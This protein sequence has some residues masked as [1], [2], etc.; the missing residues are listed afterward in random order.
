[1]FPAGQPARVSLIA[2]ARVAGASRRRCRCPT[3]RRRGA[4]LAVGRQS[5]SRLGT[6]SAIEA[7]V[8]QDDRLPSNGATEGGRTLLLPDASRGHA[9]PAKGEESPVRARRY[10]ARRVRAGS[11]ESR[12]AP[13]SLAPPAIHPL[14]RSTDAGPM[15]TMHQS[16]QH[17]ARGAPLPSALLAP[18]TQN[19]IDEPHGSPG[20]GRHFFDG[21]RPTSFD[22]A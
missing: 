9:Q 15:S 4:R 13:W 21:N 18:L 10:R 6:V 3:Q 17:R 2:S 19:R 16:S 8:R 11:D 20:L 12:G 14:S 1:M 22:G 5:T 7:I